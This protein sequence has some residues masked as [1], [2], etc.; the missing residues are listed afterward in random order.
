MGSSIKASQHPGGRQGRRASVASEGLPD[1]CTRDLSPPP[2]PGPRMSRSSKSL[3]RPSRRQPAATPPSRA[4]RPSPSCSCRSS[5]ARAASSSSPVSPTSRS[6]VTSSARPVGCAAGGTSAGGGLMGTLEHACDGALISG[7]GSQPCSRR[8]GA[9]GAGLDERGGLVA[10]RASCCVFARAIG[11]SRPAAVNRSRNLTAPGPAHATQAV[12]PVL[13][14]AV[15]WLDRVE[16][17][18]EFD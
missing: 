18:P 16:F 9:P 13:R 17:E 5:S 1:P 6:G 8:V 4:T 11:C 10:L 3:G 7:V 15:S 12:G 14:S 2:N